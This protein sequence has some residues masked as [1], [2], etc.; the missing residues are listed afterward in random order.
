MPPGAR[1]A[2]S[3]PTPAQDCTEGISAQEKGSNAVGSEMRCALKEMQT[4]QTPNT[5]ARVPTTGERKQPPLVREYLKHSPCRSVR[6]YPGLAAAPQPLLAHG[7]QDQRLD[8]LRGARQVVVRL[9]AV[10]RDLFLVRL[11][12]LDALLHLLHLRA[13]TRVSKVQQTCQ[14]LSQTR[15]KR[16]NQTATSQNPSTQLR[17]PLSRPFNASASA[18]LPSS[19]LF[20]F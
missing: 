14:T 19:P 8:R 11:Q 2:P 15:C 4:V 20:L 13:V 16:T 10:H 1:A 7:L 18:C 12:L 9:Q 6:G 17:S 5:I 3:G